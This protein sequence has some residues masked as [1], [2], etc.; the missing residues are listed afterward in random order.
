[1]HER[2][3]CSRFADSEKSC[4]FFS[5]PSHDEYFFFHFS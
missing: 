1:M 3:Q 4:V 5:L 2:P